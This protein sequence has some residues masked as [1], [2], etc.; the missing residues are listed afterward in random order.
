[1]TAVRVP[2]RHRGAAL[3]LGQWFTLTERI[4]RSMAVER[5][6]LPAIVVPGVFALGFYLPLRGIVADYGVDYAQFLMPI[7]VLQAMAFTA[8]AAAQRSALESVRGM[9]KRLRTMPIVRGAPLAARLTAGALRATLSVLASV[10][11]G[12]LLGFRFHGGIG[13]ALA[14]YALAMAFVLVLSL[15]ADAIGSLTRNPEATAQAMFL[16]QLVLGLFS[17]GFVPEEAFPSWAQGFA[18]NQPISHFATAMRAIADGTATW[19]V[20]A[21][22]LWWTVAIAV[23]VVPLAVRAERRRS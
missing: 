4:V 2:A 1:M 14:F 12:T 17:T 21:P 8:T 18:R 13:Q 20:V 9:T 22:A 6:F 23:V 16:P 10:A 15:G 5:E 11:F 7:I 19:S 3:F